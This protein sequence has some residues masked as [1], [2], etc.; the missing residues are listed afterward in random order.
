MA[1][2]EKITTWTVFRAVEELIKMYA[3]KTWGLSFVQELNQ[4]KKHG[5]MAAKKHG[6]MTDDVSA[7]AQYLCKSN[8]SARLEL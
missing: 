6:S 4:A 7:T 5:S 3:P 2:Q 1:N 8:L